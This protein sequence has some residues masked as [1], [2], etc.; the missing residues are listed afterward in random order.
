MYYVFPP[1]KSQKIRANLKILLCSISLG[2]L[3]LEVL[4]GQVSRH[5]HNQSPNQN[6]QFGNHTNLSL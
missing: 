6:P 2:S 3:L 1:K 5:T 4:Y